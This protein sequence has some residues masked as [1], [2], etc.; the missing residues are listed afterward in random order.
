[1][2]P[3]AAKVTAIGKRGDQYQWSFK[4]VRNIKAHLTLS[5]LERRS[6]K[7]VL[8]GMAG[9]TWST[10]KAPVLASGI[11]FRFGLFIDE[12]A[13]EE[14]TWTNSHAMS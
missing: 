13:D 14:G 2:S 6:L 8:F 1:M 9:L 11:R 3:I 7:W 10:I 5:P 12:R 4:S